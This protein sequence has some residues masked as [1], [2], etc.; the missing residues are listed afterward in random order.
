MTGSP[1]FP[2]FRAV[3]DCAVLVEF[4]SQT[5]PET[6]DLVR[7][8]DQALQAAR[9]P[10]LVDLVP[11]LVNLLLIFNPLLADHAGV[12]ADLRRLVQHLPP[13]STTPRRHDV[14]V[15]YDE[16]LARDLAEVARR[17][18]LSVT[19][20]VSTH[21]SGAYDV[22]MYGFAPGYA[23]LTGV[24]SALHLPRKDAAVPAV[25]AG[26]VIIAGGQCLITT[27]TM[28]TGW[29]IIGRSPLR[30][31]RPKADRPFLFDVG[32][33]LRFV[34]IDRATFDAMEQADG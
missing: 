33:E 18:Q 8:L 16:S 1:E 13:R 23:Y 4:G 17:C 9:L 29:W 28:P 7:R 5:T 21:L 3:S 14:P 30:V 34:A 26:S 10:Y 31:L 27:L 11:A 6:V 15:C 22:S 2:Q 25:P 24:P 32:D 20:V 12:T 19:E